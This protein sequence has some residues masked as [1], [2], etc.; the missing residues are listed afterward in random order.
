MFNVLPSGL[1][2]IESHIAVHQF[3]IINQRFLKT[4][5]III[6]LEDE[7]LEVRSWSW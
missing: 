4:A 5:K 1:I 6:L 2:E 7:G 3:I